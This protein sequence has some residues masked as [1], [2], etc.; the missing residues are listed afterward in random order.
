M[1][2]TRLTPVIRETGL[3]RYFAAVLLDLRP[4]LGIFSLHAPTVG[5]GDETSM[6][7]ALSEIGAEMSQW[8][9]HHP[10]VTWASGGLF[11]CQLVLQHS[12]GHWSW[13]CG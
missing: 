3:G 2:N 8:S 9:L 4:T 10:D 12:R 11:N 6:E 7:E 5:T 1:V 13:G